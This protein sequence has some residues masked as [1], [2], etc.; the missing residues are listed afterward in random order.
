[1][2]QSYN[3]NFFFIKY[4]LHNIRSILKVDLVASVRVL[5][6]KSEIVSAFMSIG[7]DV[8]FILSIV[9]FKTL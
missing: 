9:R 7:P 2:I 3:Y 8:Q 1:M 4:L 5:W 6:N